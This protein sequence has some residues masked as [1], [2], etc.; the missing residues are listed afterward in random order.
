MASAS[1]L[2]DTATQRV[3]QV[4]LAALLH[5]VGKLAQRA[6]ADPERYRSLPNL[7]EFAKY[8]DRSQQISYHHAAYTWQ[9][10]EDHLGWLTGLGEGG[11]SNVATWA[12][13]H[14]K[15]SGPWD[16]LIAEADALSAGMDR[17]HPDE[18]AARGHWEAV[19]TRRLLPLL[20]RLAGGA[21]SEW[22]VPFVRLAFDE[23]IFPRRRGARTRTEAAADYA[24][25]FA[26]FCD[27]LGEI[28]TGRVDRF[29]Q[30][31]L[32]VY[33][34][35]TW[36]VPAATNYE[37]CD[38]SLFEHSRA[39]AAIAAAL[40]SQLLHDG[41]VTIDAV[42]DRGTPRYVLAVG[43][44]S[45]IQAFIYTIVTRNAARALRGRSFALQ[46]LADGIGTH[47]LGK[48]ALPPCNVLYSGGGKVWVLAPAWAQAVLDEAAEDIDAGLQD[49]YGG[50]LGFAI[51]CVPLAGADFEQKHIGQRLEEATRALLAARRHRLRRTFT[52]DYARVF[53]PVGNPATDDLCRVCGKLSGDVQEHGG[54]QGRR[55]C[56]DCR[57]LEDLGAALPHARAL[58]RAIGPGW[59]DRLS[60]CRQRGN[61]TARQFVL[62]S[63]L[64]GGYLL[65]RDAAEALATAAPDDVVLALND[66]RVSAAGEAALGLLLAGLNRARGPDGET[67]TFDELARSS[68]GLER[69]GVLRM[70]V[71]NLGRHFSHGFRSGTADESTFSR[72]TNLS[73]ALS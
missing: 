17:G 72:L 50:R 28:P 53:G 6:E 68:I 19:Q 36:C 47:L 3:W 55:A 52:A 33:E 31:F 21:P 15:P 4:G 64:A 24:A 73:K 23:T 63:P 60:R 66:A 57:E 10:I 1:G 2:E 9:V 14:H 29:F 30:T 71:D 48:T 58:V 67:L 59:S 70:D 20:G 51:G 41:G 69:L 54:D 56:E 25:L 5:D 49:A 12:A 61:P 44:L 45:G 34:R 13:R 26:G 27:E 11:D 38:V 35:W 42:R 62:P 43:D 65:V 16:H 46:L 22:E 39:A 40:A 18:A 8:D 7:H 32:T 37:P